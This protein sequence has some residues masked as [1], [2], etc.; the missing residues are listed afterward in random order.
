VTIEIVH[1]RTISAKTSAVIDSNFSFVMD[2]EDELRA[3][4]ETGST[5][6]VIA[7]FDIDARTSVQNF[8]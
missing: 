6:T 5:I 8:T 3:I 1:Q 7:T 2:E 4:S